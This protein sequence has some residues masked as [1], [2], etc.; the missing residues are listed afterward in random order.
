[1]RQAI[2]TR[3]MGTTNTQGS[4]VRARASAGSVTGHWDYADNDDGNHCRVA[5]QLAVKYGWSGFWVAG[6]LPS[7]D[8]NVFV[9]AGET[10]RADAIGAEGRDW[11][12]IPA[13]E[14]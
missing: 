9:W 11:F 8:G 14:G 12:H 6:G 10:P 13:M 4:R 5:R 1:M 2:T 7:E 3:Y